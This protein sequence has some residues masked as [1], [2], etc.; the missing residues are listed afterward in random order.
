V[1][2]ASVSCANTA[3]AANT[4]ASTNAMAV[5]FMGVNSLL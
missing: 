1:L 2:A 5:F 4:H 3:G